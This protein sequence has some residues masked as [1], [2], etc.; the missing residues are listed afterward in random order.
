M[1]IIRKT[2]MSRDSNAIAPL[3]ALAIIAGATIVAGIGVYE[4]TQRPNVEYNIVSEGF[5]LAGLG[6]DSTTITIIIGLAIV[7][8]FWFFSNRK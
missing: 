4:F 7:V 2:K 3:I 5:S 1:G 8:G 6:I